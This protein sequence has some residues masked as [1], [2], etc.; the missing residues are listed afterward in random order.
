MQKVIINLVFI[1]TFFSSFSFLLT[2]NTMSRIYLNKYPDPLQ[3][4][5][6]L[7]PIQKDKKDVKK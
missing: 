6:L 1:T 4:R 5:L 3:L 7:L 2:V